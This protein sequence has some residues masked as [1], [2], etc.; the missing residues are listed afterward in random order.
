MTNTA[1]QAATFTLSANNNA[2][3]GLL[4]FDELAQLLEAESDTAAGYQDLSGNFK[5]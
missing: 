5:G 2:L 4:I 1:A 3:M